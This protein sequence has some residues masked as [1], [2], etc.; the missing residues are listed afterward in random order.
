[1]TAHGTSRAQV[2]DQ[3]AMRDVHDRITGGYYVPGSKLTL[4]ELSA[5]TGHDFSALRGALDHLTTTGL[6]T[7]RG[8]IADPRPDYRAERAR[9]LLSGMIERGAWPADTVLPARLVLGRLLLTEPAHLT[10]ALGALADDGVLRMEPK[11]PPRVLPAPAGSPARAPWPPG[12]TDVLDAL[13]SNTLPGAAHDADSLHL[14]AHA[15]R[16]RY[17]D[18]V[19]LPSEAMTMQ[20]GRQ[21]ETVHRLVT[22]AFAHTS[23]QA[24]TQSPTVRSTAAQV[25]ACHALPRNGPLYERL[26]R[27]TVLATTLA[28]LADAL[29]KPGPRHVPTSAP[30]AW[31][32]HAPEGP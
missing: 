28:H 15:V 27:I 29:A 23:G 5:S 8:R 12:E 7:S 3:A 16:E 10:Q 19:C 32:I 17:K 6:V 26:Y 24:T 22:Q 11:G 1:M 18:G 4:R 13:P 9:A 2:A 30:R 25:M 31:P 21:A 14:V 20:E